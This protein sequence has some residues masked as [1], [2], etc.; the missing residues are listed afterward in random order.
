MVID[1]AINCAYDIFSVDEF[2]FKLLFPDEGQDIE[3]IEDVTERHPGGDLA[4]YFSAMWKSRI[5]K[6]NALGVDALLFYG[7]YFKKE[8]YPNKR[9]SDLDIGGR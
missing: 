4:E 5:E 1:G 6:R 3:F 2:F 8:F 9:D 7:L